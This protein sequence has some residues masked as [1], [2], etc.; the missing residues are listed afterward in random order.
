M[1]ADLDTLNPASTVSIHLDLR[2]PLSHLV[3]VCVT[4]EPT[5]TA[6]LVQLPAWT[7]GSYLIRDYVRQLEGMTLG[8]AGLVVPLHRRAVA[9]W[10]ADLPSLEPVSLRYRIHATELSVRTSHLNADHGFLCLAGVVVAVEGLRWNQHRL[11]LSLPPQWQAHVPLPQQ[12][13]GTWLADDF[14]QLLDSPVE[15]GPHRSRSFAVGGVPHSWVTW[16]TTLTGLDPM[17]AD[18]HLLADVQRV[19]EACC[20]LMGETQPA[21]EQYLFVLHLNDNGYGGLEHDRSCVLQ[22]GRRRLVKANG[23]R[24][25]LQLVA[26]EYLHQWN[27]RR[28][29]PAELTP[30]DYTNPSIVPTLWFAEGVTSYFDLLLPL[31]AGLDDPAHVLEDLGEELTRYRT[32]PGRTVQSLRDSSQEAWIKLYKA[33]AYASNSQISYY[34]KGAMLALVLDL[35]L[36][37]HASSLP[38]VLRHLW[39]SHGRWGRGYREIDLLEVFTA[40]APDLAQLLPN[41][42]SG[43]ED[44]E[45]ESYLADVGLLLR[46]N[47]EAGA[48]LGWQVEQDQGGLLLTRVIRHGPAENAGLMVGDELIAMAGQRQRQVEQLTTQLALLQ[49]GQPVDLVYCRDG[50]L[51]FASL[52]P[53]AAPLENWSLVDDG[54]ASSTAIR[55]RERWLSLESP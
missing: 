20:R 31:A 49:V 19:C 38:A 9:S 2:H 42:L 55:R 7:P 50:L 10:V 36:R 5:V 47:Q 17:E 26:H 34:L 28:L 4:W 16:G 33:D 13:D 46:A 23:R 25:L 24:K 11:S 29:R 40:A 15:A 8:Q 6:L 21:A 48:W 30:V 43:T 41:W 52:V 51:R 27:V 53:S 22:F 45:F 1:R 44:P 32:T 39:R 35:H 12:T 54:Q 3:E 14:D 37:R 18:R